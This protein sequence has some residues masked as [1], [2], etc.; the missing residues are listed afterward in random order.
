MNNKFLFINPAVETESVSAA[1]NGIAY[2]SSRIKKHSFDVECLTVTAENSG[3]FINNVKAYD[4]SI[5]G[6]SCIATQIKYVIE[7]SRELEKNCPDILQ[8]AGGPGPTLDPDGYLSRTA[9]KGV[10]VGEG[11]IPIDNLLANIKNNKSVFD[12]DGFY[13]SV[14]GKI[15]KNPVCQYISDLSSLDFPDYSIFDPDEV[16]IRRPVSDLVSDGKSLAITLGRGC[17]F[18]CSYCCARALASVYHTSSDY[19]RLTSVEHG[20][21]FLKKMTETYPEAKSIF[22]Q[23]DLLISKKKWF[24]HFIEEYAKNIKLPYALCVR[25]ESLDPEIVDLLHATG[26]GM[27]C[28][29]LE[30]GNEDFR[31]RFLNRKYSNKLFIEVC[32]MMKKAGVP[33][34]TYNMI[35]FPFETRRELEDTLNLNKEVAPVWGSCSYFVP[36]KGTK[37]YE[38]CH[39]NNMLP[40]E[41][42]LFEIKGYKIGPAVKLSSEHKKDCIEF[43]E[44]IINYLD[45]QKRIYMSAKFG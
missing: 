13:W 2:L 42:E 39:E 6:F 33:F 25:A 32:A 14:D 19:F 38:I 4:P 31:K 43:R 16:C 41:D 34:L 15:R 20:I 35:G 28:I 22:F 44:K 17:P 37:L 27:A 3:E 23:D 29:G 7:Y 12:T 21:E 45:E 26:C 24:K 9:V 36:F 11:E 5:V 30:C 10:C 8:I 1:S 18:N 40:N